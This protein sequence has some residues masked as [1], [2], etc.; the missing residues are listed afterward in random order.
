M[1][2]VR[3]KILLAS[4]SLAGASFGCAAEAREYFYPRAPQAA[5]DEALI[6]F[7]N[8]SVDF[9]VTPSGKRV[10]DFSHHFIY[11]DTRHFYGRSMVYTEALADSGMPQYSIR[12]YVTKQR[13]RSMDCVPSSIVEIMRYRKT[14]LYRADTVDI[15]TLL[16]YG[17][18]EDSSGSRGVLVVLSTDQGLKDAR[19]TYF[20]RN[21]KEESI[22]WHDSLVNE[23]QVTRF[24]ERQRAIESRFFFDTLLCSESRQV[25]C[26]QYQSIAIDSVAFVQLFGRVPDRIA[27]FARRLGY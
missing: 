26:V 19:Y 15:I 20:A 7:I 27:S 21:I 9:D 4:L 3:L 6:R 11:G 1:I 8:G 2:T 10:S 12:Y 18:C 24:L 14:L 22:F 25:G 5:Y 17:V 16:F 23:Q 13:W